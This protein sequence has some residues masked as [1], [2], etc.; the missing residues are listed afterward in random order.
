[1]T[2]N[3]D[4]VSDIAATNCLGRLLSCL[5]AMSPT[6]RPVILEILYSVFSNTKLVKEAFDKVSLY[7]LSLSIATASYE[8]FLNFLKYTPE[9]TSSP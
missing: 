4:V 7:S 3:A 2:G 1:M 8:H 9:W 5:R 6:S